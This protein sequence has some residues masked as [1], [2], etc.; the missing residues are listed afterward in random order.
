MWA[1][2]T[3]SDE[4]PLL[5]Y[6]PVQRSL[7]VCGMLREEEGNADGGGTRGSATRRD[8]GGGWKY[9]GNGPLVERCDQD[10]AQEDLSGDRES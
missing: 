10:E 8:H 3:L 2:S 7:G 1:A 4:S 6:L 5:P 9:Q